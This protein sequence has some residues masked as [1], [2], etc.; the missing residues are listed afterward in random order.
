[1]ATRAHWRRLILPSLVTIAVVGLMSFG[2]ANAMPQAT[3]APKSQPAKGVAIRGCL[4]GAKLTHIEP[5]DVPL[6]LPDTLRV[7]SIR[8]IRSQVKALDG[9]QVEMI[10]TLRGIPG[11][12]N[13]LL[14]LDSDKGRLY[15]GGGDTRL[16]E[17][18]DPA[19]NDP[20]TMHAHTIKDIASACTA[21]QTQ[22]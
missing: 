7:T 19:R 11:L 4:T 16:G 8:I 12:E 17:D 20:P 13:G 5:G 10:G 3:A 9:H 21:G 15:I 22:H 2:A 18:L 1:M 6:S 14:V